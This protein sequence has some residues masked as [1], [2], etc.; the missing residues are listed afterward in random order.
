MGSRKEQMQRLTE[1]RE[2]YLAAIHQHQRTIE[3]L[4]N[5][6]AGVDA[7]MNALGA[8]PGTAPPPQRNVKRAVLDIVNEAGKVGVTASEVISAAAAKGRTLKAGTVASLLSR[9][10]QEKVL[11]FDGERYY[12]A[13]AQPQKPALEIVKAANGS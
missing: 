11:T 13:S 3:S 10:K 4:Q 5:Q 7:A 9:F 1:L 2:R 6:L 8:V 12:A